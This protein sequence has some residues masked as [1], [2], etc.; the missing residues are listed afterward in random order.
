MNKIKKA[1][2]IGG[3]LVGGLIGGSLSVIGKVSRKKL[4]DDLGSN[5]VDSTLLTGKITGDMLSGTTHLLI[6]KIRKKPRCL[7]QGKK[8]L[9]RAGSQVVDNFVT[10][11]KQVL[12]NTGDLAGG[13][14]KRD[15]KRVIRS[16]KTLGKIATVGTLTVGAILV[17]DEEPAADS[18]VD[19][20][21]Y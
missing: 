7:K 14:V 9:Q 3:A 16:L 13:I 1:A 5:I 8:D 18:T 10:N 20:T 21:N 17:P 15:K 12:R 11:T 2:I 4:L 6:G 19:R